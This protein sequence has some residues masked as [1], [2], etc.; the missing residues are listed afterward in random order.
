VNKE[1]N[2]EQEYGERIG[3]G[4]REQ[5]RERNLGSGNGEQE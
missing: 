2:R 5:N 4:N 1:K 3:S